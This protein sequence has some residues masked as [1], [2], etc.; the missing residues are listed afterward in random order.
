[1]NTLSGMVSLI[2]LPLFM[3]VILLLAIVRKVDAYTCFTE[4]ARGGI[5]LCIRT[6]P[7]VAAMM[8]A[9]RIFEAAGGFELL[10]RVFSFMLE[11]LGIPAVLLPLIVTRP[12]SGSGALGILAGILSAFGPDSFEA[13]AACFY[14]GSSETIFYV[15]SL[16]FGSVR[17]R[18]TRYTVPIALAADFAGLF[19][20][21]LFANL[22][23]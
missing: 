8:V 13:R 23:F 11:P 14:M 10:S 20:A 22:L 17:I 3:A 15:V 21:C 2:A 9:A 1:M 16:Y 6:L 7:H 18:K 19:F 5:G 12:F 4:G